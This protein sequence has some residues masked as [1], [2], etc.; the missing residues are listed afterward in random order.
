VILLR[1][2][3]PLFFSLL[4][5]QI[6]FWGFGMLFFERNP[7]VWEVVPA[8]FILTTI[9]AVIG[10][11]TASIV[12]NI[13]RGMAL[14]KRNLNLGYFLVGLPLYTTSRTIMKIMN[15]SVFPEHFDHLLPTH[16]LDLFREPIKSWFTAQGFSYETYLKVYFS[17]VEPF[18]AE[19]PRLLLFILVIRAFRQAHTTTT[20]SGPS[21]SQPTP[22]R[23]QSPAS[24]R[25]RL[26][27]VGE[28]A[29][30]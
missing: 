9:R 15:L 28:R 8:W 3:S 20:D 14:T 1:A 23:S 24:P 6:D 19:L 2:L 30:S 25:Q 4:L 13:S 22:Q 21:P 16:F 18:I 26:R 11:L 29:N 17:S 27:D 10:I 12:L 5:F 7:P